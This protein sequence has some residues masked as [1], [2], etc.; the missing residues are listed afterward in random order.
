MRTSG[1]TLCRHSSY[2]CGEGGGEGSCTF[3]LAVS[4]FNLDQ[5]RLLSTTDYLL[6]LCLDRSF[7]FVTKSKLEWR[8][9]ATEMFVNLGI[10]SFHEMLR[11][12][13]FGF[14]FRVTTSYYQLLS[15]LCSAHCSVYSKL[16]AWW[17]S[18]TYY[19]IMS[20]ITP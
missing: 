14:R 12:Y 13:I 3:Y 16:W 19:N 11:I 5:S 2:S 8:Y 4:R 15:S 9:S 17:N 7:V 1:S 6:T 18:L 20:S 10:N